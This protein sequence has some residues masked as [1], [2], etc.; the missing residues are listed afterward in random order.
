MLSNFKKD[1]SVF[2]RKS[3]NWVHNAQLMK[4][5][6]A[7]LILDID[8]SSLSAS[9]A[10]LGD[11]RLIVC[12]PNTVQN[13][14]IFQMNDLNMN[15]LSEREWLIQEHPKEDHFIVGNRLFGRL[16]CTRG[17]IS[18]LDLKNA[19]ES[20]IHTI[21]SQDLEM[22]ITSFRR[23]FSVTVSTGNILMPSLP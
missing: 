18:E 12:D 20:C 16:M 11:C 4:S 5:G 17:D 8:L 3:S 6:S 23:G 13:A 10:N 15:T 1:H 21:C 7:A 19:A 14:V 9:Y 22:G 2:R